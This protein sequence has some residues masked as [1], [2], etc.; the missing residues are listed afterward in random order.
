M[1][2]ER[3][4]VGYPE[5]LSDAERLLVSVLTWVLLALLVKMEILAV[6]DI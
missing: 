3:G 6:P 2:K 5:M 4:D 1:R